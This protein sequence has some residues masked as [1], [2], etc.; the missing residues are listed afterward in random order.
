MNQQAMSLERVSPELRAKLYERRKRSDVIDLAEGEDTHCNAI[1]NPNMGFIDSEHESKGPGS[2]AEDDADLSASDGEPLDYLM[3]AVASR[4][5]GGEAAELLEKIRRHEDRRAR[6]EQKLR[7][8]RK[9]HLQSHRH[10]NNVNPQDSETAPLKPTLASQTER[11]RDFTTTANTCQAS[12]HE[13][14]ASGLKEAASAATLTEPDKLVS[15]LIRQS[16]VDCN[17]CSVRPTEAS[18]CDKP[19]DGTAA[20]LNINAILPRQEKKQCK[21]VITCVCMA[22]LCMLALVL[23]LLFL[24][25][26]NKKINKSMSSTAP[27]DKFEETLLG[28]TTFHVTSGLSSMMS[29]MQEF[30]QQSLA[31]QRSV[32]ESAAKAADA[33]ARA[34]LSAEKAAGLAS[35]NRDGGSKQCHQANTNSDT[36]SCSLK[37]VDATQQRLASE[38]TEVLER[39]RAKAVDL[40]ARQ[41][42]QQ[43]LQRAM[44]TAAERLAAQSPAVASGISAQRRAALRERVEALEEHGYQVLVRPPDDGIE[45]PLAQSHTGTENDNNLAAELQEVLTNAGVP[46]VRAT[47]SA[48]RLARQGI[49]AADLYTAS[50]EELAAMFSAPELNLLAGERFRV[51]SSLRQRAAT[52][53]TAAARGS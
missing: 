13:A 26:L 6:T 37:D 5:P 45:G 17:V 18:A 3:L 14:E 10:C 4:L 50:P 2:D 20:S 33:A 30:G 39:T 47:T 19:A 22:A 38:A 41:A 1:A 28:E 49:G 8:H 31:T 16:D 51:L 15:P 36:E 11:T 42:M 25:I 44:E 21:L 23:G 53:V 43:Q 12:S 40:A 24:G 35:L 7:S 52:H 46:H 34:A 27:R 9:R 32:M 29:M 48:T